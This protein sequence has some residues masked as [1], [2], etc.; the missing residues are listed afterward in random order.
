VTTEAGQ[1]NPSK[2]DSNASQ[3]KKSKKKCACI[4]LVQ[5]VDAFWPCIRGSYYV[6]KPCNISQFHCQ[7]LAFILGCYILDFHIY[8]CNGYF[9]LDVLLMVYAFPVSLSLTFCLKI[10]VCF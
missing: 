9:K 5:L 7:V 6:S 2:N 4:F 3:K 1:R 8:S 10:Y